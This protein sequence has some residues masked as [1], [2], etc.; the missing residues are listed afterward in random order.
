MAAHNSLLPLPCPDLKNLG[1]LGLALTPT[2]PGRV[3]PPYVYRQTGS[4][5]E[6]TLQ[7]LSRT[8]RCSGGGANR[9]DC[10]AGLSQKPRPG[11]NGRDMLTDSQAGGR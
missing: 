7:L 2:K 9:K 4:R 5:N 6:G 8:G 3:V 11:C 10:R 1:L